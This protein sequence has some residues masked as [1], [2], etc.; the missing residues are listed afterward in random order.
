[1]IS[2]RDWWKDGAGDADSPPTSVAP[3]YSVRDLELLPISVSLT[4]LTVLQYSFEIVS[5]G[6][7]EAK[8]AGDRPLVI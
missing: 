2:L 6:D 7:N 3:R 1:M 5:R 8:I 4:I